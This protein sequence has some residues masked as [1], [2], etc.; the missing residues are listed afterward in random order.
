ML[1]PGYMVPPFYDSLLG[2][3]IV[4]DETRS[5]ALARLRDALAGLVVDGIK[6]TISLHAALARDP[7]IAAGHV[8]TG[9][10]EGWLETA[11]L[12]VSP[13]DGVLASLARDPDAVAARF[14]IGKPEGWREIANPEI[15]PKDG[16]LTP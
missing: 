2:K 1:Y 5:G 3:L 9:W 15:S 13:K 16:V 10:L 4:W 12:D 8:H 6:T 7:D 11:N 14:H